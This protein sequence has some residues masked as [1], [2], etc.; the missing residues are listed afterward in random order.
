M[1]NE[2]TLPDQIPAGKIFNDSEMWV[3]TI[4][5]GPLT[6]GYII[7]Q[8]F[9]SFGEPGKARKSLL[10]AVGATILILGIAFFAPY[11]E[12][13]PNFFF[14]LVYTVIAYMIYQLYQGEKVKAHIAGGGM[15][16][17]WRRTVGVSAIGLIITLIPIIGLAVVLN[18]AANA[19]LTTKT[20]GTMKNQIVF[21]KNNISEAEVDKIASGLVQTSLFN[22][23]VQT[24]VDVKNAGNAG[25]ITIYCTDKINN[26]PEAMNYFRDLRDEMQ[27][28]SP[29]RKIVFNLAVGSSDNIVKRLE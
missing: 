13:V 15:I 18:Y 5:G 24:L 9:K 19:S 10:I 4:L 1:E 21:D 28:T 17:S 8:N 25:E 22:D 3:G 12:R 27:K 16:Q 14:A 29:D 7:A 2:A 23:Q 6:A 20:Y 11:V 26:N